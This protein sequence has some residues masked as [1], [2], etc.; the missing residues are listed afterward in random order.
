MKIFVTGALG[1][2]GSHFVKYT[3]DN[4]E[5]VTVVGFDLFGEEKNLR[6]LENYWKHERFQMVYGDL[7]D[8]ISDALEGVDV[9]IHFAAKTFVDH[10]FRAAKSH[11]DTNIG[12]TFNLLE[13]VRKLRGYK[14]QETVYVQ[15]STDEVYVQNEEVF[16][17]E[18]SSL[19]PTNPYSATKAAA[20]MLVLGWSNCYGIPTII[21]RTENNYGSYQHIQKVLPVFVRKA[22][23]DEPLPVYGDGKHKRMWLHVIDHCSAIWFLLERGARGIYHIAGGE[24]LENIKLANKILNILKKPEGMLTF[25]PDK[26]IRPAHDRRYALDSTKLE[27]MG[28]KPSKSVEE[29]IEETVRWYEKNPWWLY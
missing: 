21:T 22:L 20:D 12:G 17:D 24:E 16:F 5:D 27:K 26:N 9:V 6:R 28:W 8:D 15:V 19:N 1:F 13:E 10:S 11:I 2:I 4:K 18:I 29:G 23:N 3:L 25:I 14:G 7:R